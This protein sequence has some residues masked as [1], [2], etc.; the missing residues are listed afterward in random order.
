M[1]ARVVATLAEYRPSPI[2]SSP[3]SVSPKSLACRN[4]HSQKA[5]GRRQDGVG[6]VEYYLKWSE[7]EYADGE[8]PGEPFG[9]GQTPQNLRNGFPSELHRAIGH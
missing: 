5:D 3:Q 7:S 2:W 6:H 4:C 1:R 8:T 9:V